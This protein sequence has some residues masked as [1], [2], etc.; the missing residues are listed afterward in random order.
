M[1][2]LS[3]KIQIVQG[4]WD[5]TCTVETDL[6]Q[7]EIAYPVVSDVLSYTE[8]R[9]TTTLIVSGATEGYQG[10]KYRDDIKTKIGKIPEGQLIGRAGYRYRLMGRI[11][12][13]SVILQQVGQS[14]S[15]GT[16]Q[17]LMQDNYLTPGMNAEFHGGRFTARVYTFSG[18]AGNYV[19]T[20]KSVGGTVF[21]W[22]T[23]VSGQS[24][25][26]TC[27]GGYNSMS[28]KS[29]RG[30]DRTHYPDMY[31]NHTTI[32]RK[33][34]GISGSAEST[35]LWI[36]FDG[37][38]GW[39]YE[40]IQQMRGRARVEDEHQKIWGKTNMRGADGALLASPPDIDAET[41]MPITQGDGIWEQ[42]KGKNDTYTSGIA[43]RPT[44]SD[45]NEMVS[46]LKEKA[47][48]IEGNTW[49]AITGNEGM[50]NANNILK[51]E[52]TAN[53]HIHID[54]NGNEV[55]GGKEIAVGYT[56]RRY[57]VNGNS[58]IFIEHPLFSD[59]ERWTD[60]ANDGQS[61][62][63]SSYL[64]LCNYELDSG[65]NNIE[66]LGRGA[67]GNNRTMVVGKIHGMTG[68]IAAMGG[69]ITTS[70]DEDEYHLLKEDGIFVY[71]ATCCGL[72]HR[73]RS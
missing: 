60:T 58:I 38:K 41:G 49:Y 14:Q 69:T 46:N 36:S 30:Y 52:A 6:Q 27:F 43:G 10:A 53:Y 29:I 73:Q 37:N 59:R 3:N 65:K 48:D 22:S 15:D 72:M 5:Q 13:A 57:N 54:G 40:A 44:I 42:V 71:D 25:T 39:M 34:K 11:Q 9:M 12:K 68:A 70:V 31:I 45:F 1:A 2:D 20:F 8:K 26:K 66:I 4:A 24:G 56:W 21:S 32:Q 63:G 35:V 28:E 62:M 50:E 7:N 64:F 33:S 18:T 51:A 47:Q 61:I 16:F 55:A 17:L 23:H 19:Y 67:Y